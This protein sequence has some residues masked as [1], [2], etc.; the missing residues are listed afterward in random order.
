M[1]I[2]LYF[3][4]LVAFKRFGWG[5]LALRVN[6]LFLA[7]FF[8]AA[9]ALAASSSPMTEPTPNMY[10]A[11]GLNTVPNARMDKAGTVRLNIGGADP[12]IHTSLG[13][14]I[15]DRFYLALRQTGEF[16]NIREDP[17]KLMP[18]MDIKLKL[19]NEKN[20]RPEISLG[21]QSAF[22]HKRMA[23]EYLA[24]TKRYEDWDFTG[25]FGWGRFGTRTHTPNPLDWTGSYFSKHRELDGEEPNSPHDW[26][27]GD[28]G[29]FA[30]VEYQTG[31]KG[32][33]LKADWSSDAYKAERDL[34]LKR[35]WP[36]SFGV[37]YKPAAWI[38]AGAAI[39]D[40]DTFMARISFRSMVQNWP[41]SP[42]GRE[43]LLNVLPY[44]AASADGSGIIAEG[45]RYGLQLDNIRKNGSE[46]SGQVH[47]GPYRST[48]HQMSQ[49]WRVVANKSGRD[50]ESM[51][52]E[53]VYFGL[54]GPG[55]TI[56]RRDLE[57]AARQK[58]SA[59][60]IWRNIEYDLS[61]RSSKKSI[62]RYFPYFTLK[63]DVSLSEDDAGLI[64]RTALLATASHQ[65]FTNFLTET[66]FRLN[67]LS[68]MDEL[69]KYR[70]VGEDPIRSD[71]DRYDRKFSIE[72]AFIQGFKSFSINW[73]AS[74]SAGYL[75]ELYA[76]F[77][78]EVLYRPWGK[79]WAAGFEAA[80]VIKRDYEMPLN[81]G[82]I[83]VSR[84]T[85]HINFY[86]EFPNTDLTLHASAGQYLAGDRGGSFSIK[87]RFLNGSTLEAFITATNYKDPDVYGGESNFYSGLR[88]SLPLGSLKYIPDGSGIEVN[89]SALGRDTGQRLETAHTLYDMTEPLS[90]RHV[91]QRW[92]D[93]TK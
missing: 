59:E 15:S 87:N 20:I 63:E 21:L 50:P 66:S 27:T 3:A 40:K 41:F 86:Y 12:Y 49:A 73:H 10:G 84:P 80:D 68:S 55:I 62:D 2:R 48:P 4:R 78:G 69:S 74:A 45:E 17:D 9:P 39:L 91:T 60:E 8:A 81:L 11:L 1:V 32:L 36:F 18:G 52:L 82:F 16:S 85:A 24:F 92:M 28:T 22:G 33:S 57:D 19:F 54:K 51:K 37:N 88:F 90:Y 23:G 43:D 93:V 35:P 83:D 71:I 6:A 31:W 29:F 75:E 44:R 64:H 65:F 34:G 7:C 13:F 72:R 76:G 56:N 58:G 25:G 53:A 67:L 61:A 14:Q 77:H 46:V 38:D 47:L 70:Q 26:F 89:A 79:N 30:G 42:A 5:T